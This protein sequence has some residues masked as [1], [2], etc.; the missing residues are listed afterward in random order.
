L[1]AAP[2]HSAYADNVPVSSSEQV[3]LPYPKEF[4]APKHVRS[5]LVMTSRG[6][7]EQRG[8]RAAYLEALPARFHAPIFES[9]A[10]V[11]LP[12]EMGVAHYSACEALGLSPEV[13]LELGRSVSERVRGTLLGTVVRLAKGGGITPLTVMPH[14]QRFW[15]RAFDGGGVA[16]HMVGPKEARL[17]AQKVPLYEIPY[18]RSA[19]RGLVLGILDLFCAKAYV[20][21]GV[22]K[23][24]Y[25]TMSYRVQ[26]A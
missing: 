20:I 18:F 14:F 16:L 21:E 19:V 10:G 11:W 17:Y 25:G 4:D 13:Q 12:I 1:I 9:V 15:N 22:G 2:R 5:T 23:R 7:I 3:L 8:Y 6:A 26:W 24:A